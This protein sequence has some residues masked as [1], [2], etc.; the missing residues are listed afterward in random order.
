MAFCKFSNESA[1]KNS[2]IIDNKF[3]TDYMLLAP[4]VCV[5]VYLLGLYNCQ[6]DGFNNTLESFSRQLGLTEEDVIE[7]FLYWQE[8][9]LVTLLNIDPIEVRYL[10]VKTKSNDKKYSKTKYANFNK[11]IQEII[12]GRMITPTEYAEY[13]SLIESFHIEPDALIMIAKYCTNVKGKN[14]GYSYILTVAKNW[15]YENVKTTKDVEEKLLQ[16]EA[17][18]SDVSEILKLLGSKKQADFEDKQMFVRWT[19]DLGFEK[20]VILFVAK[21]FKKKGSIEQLNRKLE[22]Y[23]ELKLLSEKEIEAYEQSKQD[24][25]STAKMVTKQIGVYYENLEN[26][27]ETYI[28]KW[29]NMGYNADSL[30]LIAD[31]CFKTNIK[32]LEGMNDTVEKFYSLGLTGV[33]SIN[34]YFGE[35]LQTDG[36]IKKILSLVGLN[37]NVSSWDRDFYRTWTFTWNFSNNIIEY[38]CSFAVN[39]SHPLAY[40]NKILSDWYKNHIDTIEKAKSQKIVVSD[41]ANLKPATFE[42][43]SYSS[44]EINALFDNLKEVKWKWLKEK[45]SNK[46]Y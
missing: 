44:D 30:K 45:L 35:I 25:L 20:E 18:A 23:Y 3:V 5:K 26:V 36:Y 2:T 11:Q 43:R 1:V 19:K 15:A 6:N 34:Q 24:L 39:K 29:Q 13:Y 8:Q 4:D 16:H 17:I 37:R 40:V 9:G 14:V 28:V 7:C 12:E 27:I 21:S 38:A 32:T 42:Q 46:F 10:P 41:I 33:E 22:K 31:F